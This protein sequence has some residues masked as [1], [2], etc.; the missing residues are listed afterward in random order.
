MI[1]AFVTVLKVIGIFLLVLIGAL[2]LI[3]LLV[4]F[5]PVRYSVK[6][7]RREDGEDPV[8]CHLKAT[9]L[10]H[11][12]NVHFYYP[13][14]VFLRVRVF[15]ITVFRLRKEKD[16]EEKESPEKENTPSKENTSSRE[17]ASSRGN[18]FS[19]ENTS[20]KENASSKEDCFDNG[21]TA[22]EEQE[23]K[24]EEEKP[25]LKGFFGKLFS[26]LR[27]IRYT[28]GQICDKIK[29]IVRNIQYY[30]SILKSDAFGRAFGVCRDQVWKLLRTIRPRKIKGR[31]RIGTGDPA[32]TGQ[33]FA[34]Y[35]ILYP[36]LGS[37][38]LVT[39]D[40]DR[41]VIEGEVFIKGKITVFHFLK[42]AW[43]IYFNRDLH[44]IIKIFKREA[45]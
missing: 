30:L 37:Q 28:I 1:P 43:I 4:L 21:K 29:H 38:I 3:A 7:E 27:N 15:F 17:N 9:W 44:H 11:I 42:A 19:K 12:L 31:I 39:P 18:T 16:S 25:T 14:V 20:S 6:A 32:S 5:V 45:A 34:I 33:V 13:G 10:L 23:T 26:I 22:K 8:I 36:I 2:L 35:G 24:E 40:F 41:K